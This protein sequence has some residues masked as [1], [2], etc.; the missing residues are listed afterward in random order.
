MEEKRIDPS[1]V[2]GWGVDA[3]PENEPTWPIRKRVASEHAG[4]NWPRPAQQPVNVEVLHS[5]ER[6][7]RQR[8]L[9]HLGAAGTA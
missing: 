2:K 5:I 9:R 8:H 4:Y 3:D 6:P 7:K 1:Q